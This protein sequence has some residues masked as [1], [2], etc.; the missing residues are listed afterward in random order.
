MAELDQPGRTQIYF[1]VYEAISQQRSFSH[2]ASQASAKGAIDYGLAGGDA[3]A[4][5]A[6]DCRVVDTGVAEEVV[7]L[8]FEVERVLVLYLGNIGKLSYQFHCG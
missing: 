5:V 4:N 2:I 3:N 8:L 7:P 1:S 6:D